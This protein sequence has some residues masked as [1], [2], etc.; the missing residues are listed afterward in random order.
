MLRK[1][2]EQASQMVEKARQERVEKMK[3]AKT[4]AE[5][6]INQYRQQQEAKLLSMAGSDAAE[7]DLLSG[8]A[9]EGEAKI[10]KMEASVGANTKEVTDLLLQVVQKVDLVVPEA[11]K[12]LAQ[13]S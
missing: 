3:A 12:N 7:Q 1:A 10:K 2:E 6:D 11:R 13:T 8:L 9:A 4:E 5:E